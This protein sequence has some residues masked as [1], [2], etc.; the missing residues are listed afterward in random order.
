MLKVESPAQ[1]TGPV[2]S[3][4]KALLLLSRPDCPACAF[5]RER[6]ER[7]GERNSSLVVAVADVTR[8]PGLARAMGVSETPT[9]VLFRRGKRI[10]QLT[11]RV[12]GGQLQ[13]LV[14]SV[15][16]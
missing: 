8:V 6:L 11:G 2:Q 12:S 13:D 3:A 5:T 14:D 7:I 16:W 9:V 10:S 1:I 15:L 4:G